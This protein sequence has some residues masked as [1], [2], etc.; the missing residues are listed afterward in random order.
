MTVGEIQSFIEAWAPK[1]IAWERDNTGLQVG[2]PSDGV[3]GILVTLD[4]TE[5]VVSEARKKNANLIISHHPLLFRPLRSITPLSEAGRVLEGLLRGRINL[6]SAH[7]NLDF[8]RGGTSFVLAEVLELKNVDFLVRSH[9]IQ[10]KVVTF[11]PVDHVDRVAGAMASAGAGKIGNYERCSFRIEGVG[12]FQG[13]ASSNP[14]VGQRD[15]LEQVP[16]IRLEMVVNQ[17][18]VDKVICALIA[19][20]PYEEVAYD[21]Y[22]TENVQGDYGVGIIGE[23]RQSVPLKQLLAIVKKR[24]AAPCPRF[25]GDPEKSVQRVAACGGSGSEFI[26]EAITK[27]ADVFI[28]ADVKYHAFLEAAKKITLVDAGH[29]ETEYPV[30]REL[31]NRLSGEMRRLNSNI[32]VYAASMSTNPIKYYV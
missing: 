18:D 4:V 6:Y 21:V 15:R 25:T 2:D 24:L 3:Q 30:V 29:F 19:S 17:W 27:G 11:V 1:H 23:L 13:N 10:K 32:E 20:H 8:T 9:H 22:P 14:T 28:T 16:E 7:T 12:T 26:S 31:V 5:E